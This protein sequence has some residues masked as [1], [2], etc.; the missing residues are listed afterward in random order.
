[1]WNR[2]LL[3]QGKYHRFERIKEDI[4]GSGWLEA[5]FRGPEILAR[6]ERAEILYYG[7]GIGGFTTVLKYP[8]PLG[9]AEYTMAIGG[10]PDASSRGD[11]KTQTLSAH[12]PMLFH[13]NPRTVMVVGLASGVTAGEVL[14]Y[15]I[16]QLD[17]H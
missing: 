17:V 9:N 4:I 8:A 6:S 7:D 13:P 5:L 3:S 15:P 12:F 10:K 1:M 16:E 14:H 2:H 11:M